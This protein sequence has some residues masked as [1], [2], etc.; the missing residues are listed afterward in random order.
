VSYE[1]KHNLANGEDGRDGQDAN[2]SANYGQEG[3]CDDPAVLAVRVRQIK[4]FLL[5][6]AVSRGIPMLLAGDEIRRTQG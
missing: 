6:L 1:R 2:Y 3:P 5:T 4:N